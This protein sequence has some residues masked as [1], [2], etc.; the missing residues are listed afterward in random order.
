[1]HNTSRGF[2]LIELMVTT[3]IFVFMTA[4]I[5]AKYG[6]FNQG[7][8]LTNLGYD[9][10]LMVR[11]A[12]NAGL[13]A[14]SS[15][16]STQNQSY[17]VMLTVNPKVTSVIEY[18]Q[19]L[20]GNG[21]LDKTDTLLSLYNMKRGAYISNLCVGADAADCNPIYTVSISYK[22]PNPDAVIYGTDANQVTTQRMDY[23]RITL[24]S[25]TDSR[26]VEVYRNG[27]ISVIETPPPVG[28]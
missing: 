15:E 12:Q 14:I 17:G 19:D 25:G 18:Y 16:T 5:I 22:R 24:T 20:D 9:T 7:T 27:Q 13:N 11:T 10:A 4:L 6:S 21:L 2:T 26:S 23:A 1:M 28:P 8:L 3:G